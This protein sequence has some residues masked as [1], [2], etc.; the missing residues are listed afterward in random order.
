MNEPE[1]A[2]LNAG[3]AAEGQRYAQNF[4]VLQQV[5][6]ARRSGALQ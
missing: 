1:A 4:V 6:L 5:V 2:V 3:R